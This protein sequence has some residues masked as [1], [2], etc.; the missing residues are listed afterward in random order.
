MRNNLKDDLTVFSL[1]VGNL[2]DQIVL[3]S[4]GCESH[5]IETERGM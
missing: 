2:Q 1:C 5:W 3:Q 4:H